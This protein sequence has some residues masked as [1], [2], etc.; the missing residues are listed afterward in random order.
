MPLSASG[1]DALLLEASFQTPSFTDW[2]PEIHRQYQEF[3]FTDDISDA[4]RIDEYKYVSEQLRKY[5]FS[6]QDQ[7]L[8]YKDDLVGMLA[9]V[10][11]LMGK[12]KEHAPGRKGLVYVAMRDAWLRALYTNIMMMINELEEEE[13]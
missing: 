2:W 12:A 6:K 10:E 5:I 1:D 8:S 4:T 9:E 7:I 13:E 3:G 11:G